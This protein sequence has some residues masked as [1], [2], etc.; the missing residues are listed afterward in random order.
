MP[1]PG[2][3][4]GRA[5]ALR[6][7]CRRKV[8]HRGGKKPRKVQCWPLSLP[9]AVVASREGVS[10]AVPHRGLRGA[11]CP[12]RPW[13]GGG[14]AAAVAGAGGLN[15]APPRGRRTMRRQRPGGLGA[16]GPVSAG[17]GR[18]GQGRAALPGAGGG[19]AGRCGGPCPVPAARGAGGSRAVPRSAGLGGRSSGACRGLLPALLPS[20]GSPSCSLHLS[21]L[22]AT[23]FPF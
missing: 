12:A 3:A 16:A 9:L 8:N 22:S 7:G 23:G 2:A 11:R 6:K 10:A 21:N 15:A 17:A 4:P 18:A 20:A 13:G 5:P 1:P 19:L 14:A